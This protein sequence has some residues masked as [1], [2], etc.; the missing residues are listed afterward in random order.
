[1]HFCEVVVDDVSWDGNERYGGHG[2]ARGDHQLFGFWKYGCGYNII[3]FSFSLHRFVSFQQPLKEIGV[4]WGL[5][6]PL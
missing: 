6:N 4:E 5:F 1:M 2:G 3:C